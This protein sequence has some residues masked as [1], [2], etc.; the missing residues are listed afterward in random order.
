MDAGIYYPLKLQHPTMENHSGTKRET[1]SFEFN[2]L[3]KGREL[4]GIQVDL[5]CPFSF[6]ITNLHLAHTKNN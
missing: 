3:Q 6:K 1:L 2:Q 5:K 4:K